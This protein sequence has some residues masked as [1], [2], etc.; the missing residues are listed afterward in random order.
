MSHTFKINDL[1]NRTAVIPSTS[2]LTMSGGFAS[3][4]LISRA[5]PGWLLQACLGH[6]VA[7]VRPKTADQT[8]GQR[9]IC[10]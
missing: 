5:S 6:T 8:G 7:T 4:K 9:L 1:S 3:V 10:A 2:S